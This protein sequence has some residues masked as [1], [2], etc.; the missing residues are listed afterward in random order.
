MKTV[1][2]FFFRILVRKLNSEIFSI[3]SDKF[4]HNF[5]FSAS[6]FTCPWFW[7]SVD[8]E[9]KGFDKKVLDFGFFS[10]LNPEGKYKSVFTFINILAFKMILF[11]L[12]NLI[13]FKIISLLLLNLIA[14]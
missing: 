1:F 14:F 6:S 2:V 4:L 8:C 9:K 5:H 3:Y 7:E 11:L 10:N 12:L 13:A